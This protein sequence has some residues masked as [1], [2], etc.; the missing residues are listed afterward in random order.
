MTDSIQ[1]RFQLVNQKIGDACH[2]AG[3]AREEVHLIVVTKGHT[4][5]SI[6]KVVKAGGTILGENYPEE[7]IS[8]IEEIDNTVKPSWHMIGHLQS[9]KIKLMH[10]AFDCIHSIDSLGLAQ[11][12]NRYYEERDSI[13]DVMLEV[14]ISGEESKYGFNASSSQNRD[15]LFSVFEEICSLPHLKTIGLMTMPPYAKEPAQ[16][17]ACY[18][19]C[20]E[21]SEDIREKFG[22]TDFRQLS[23][24][25]S[26]D[27]ETAIKCGA[28]YIRVGEAIMGKRIIPKN[29]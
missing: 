21:F 4:A 10:P 16:N 15:S 8:K 13:I 11:K 24:G 12:L 2:D 5:D 23:M 1:E 20:Q 3:R 18:N 28:T 25:T 26:A 6:I 14:N 17:E 29:T 22:L 19:L 7:T 9:R 27:F